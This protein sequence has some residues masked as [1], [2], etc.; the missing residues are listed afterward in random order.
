M[1]RTEDFGMEES[2]ASSCPRAKLWLSLQHQAALVKR[3]GPLCPDEA[4]Y[5]PLQS[6]ALLASRLDTHLGKAEELLQLAEDAVGDAGAHVALA[7]ADLELQKRPRRV[8]ARRRRSIG[9]AGATGVAATSTGPGAV[10]A[11]EAVSS[12]FRYPLIEV[13]EG[14]SAMV[15]SDE[16]AGYAMGG[17]HSAA[18]ATAGNGFLVGGGACGGGGGGGACGGVQLGPGRSDLPCAD[19]DQVTDQAGISCRGCGRWFHLACLGLPEDMSMPSYSC[20]SCFLN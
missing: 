10:A 18:D 13:A 11:D 9:A 3:F 7:R 16:D 6:P 17:M 2:A 5:A 12:L 15:A 8:S 14:A 19:C 4:C 20:A 1:D